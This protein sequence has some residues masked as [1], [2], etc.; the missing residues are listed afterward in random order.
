MLT[1]VVDRANTLTHDRELSVLVHLIHASLLVREIDS[2]LRGRL[3]LLL[4]HARLCRV[5]LGW[6][7]VTETSHHIVLIT[8]L[9]LI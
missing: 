1:C 5:H 4:L 6:I 2:L 7:S 8:K 9:V 3:L